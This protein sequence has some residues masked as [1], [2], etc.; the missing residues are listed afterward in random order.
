MSYAPT[1]MVIHSSPSSPPCMLHMWAYPWCHPDLQTAS[2]FKGPP[3]WSYCPGPPSKLTS[4]GVSI[5]FTRL[6]KNFGYF[7]KLKLRSCV[8]IIL[9]STVKGL[10]HNFAQGLKILRGGPRPT[11]CCFPPSLILSAYPYSCVPKYKLL[12]H[13]GFPLFSWPDHP[14]LLR[15]AAAAATPSSP[16]PSQPH[17]VTCSV[18]VSPQEWHKVHRS[19]QMRDVLL[20]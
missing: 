10:I 11:S 2:S 20:T 8:T 5:V 9:T 14:L 15:N 3:Y 19:L 1:S 16:P 13:L 7:R 6:T 12:L 18:K 17:P 4:A